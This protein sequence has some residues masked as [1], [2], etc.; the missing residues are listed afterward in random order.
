MDINDNDKLIIFYIMILYAVDM[1]S[2][3]YFSLVSTISFKMVNDHF[4]RFKNDY[5]NHKIN[6]RDFYDP[7]SIPINT[8]YD[9]LDE[10]NNKHTKNANLSINEQSDIFNIY[11]KLYYDEEYWPIK[12]MCVYMKT[13][14]F[15]KILKM[16]ELR[17][18]Y[19]DFNVPNVR[20][21]PPRRHSPSERTQP[22]SLHS[23]GIRLLNGEREVS[24]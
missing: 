5:M 10:L 7:P 1:R 4:K 12:N 3:V 22:L 24:R 11:D 17:D 6:F 16:R 8:W 2:I 23:E 20:F 13:L 9:I 18:L 19:L 15:N 14:S 21:R